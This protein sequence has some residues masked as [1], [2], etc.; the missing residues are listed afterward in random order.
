MSSPRRGYVSYL[1][2]LWQVGK[3]ENTQVR[4]SLESP[5]TGDRRGF[6]SLAALFAFLE[7][8]VSQVVQGQPIPGEGGKGGDVNKP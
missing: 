2:R 5:H 7:K 8:E 4:A 6:P 1:L 3:G